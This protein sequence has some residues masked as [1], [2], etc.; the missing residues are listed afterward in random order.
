MAGVVSRSREPARPLPHGSGRAG[1]RDMAGGI[2][3]NLMSIAVGGGFVLL[4]W[5][6]MKATVPSKETM[7]KVGTSQIA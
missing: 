1:S 5:G 7:L 6:L 3:R 2:A 4:G